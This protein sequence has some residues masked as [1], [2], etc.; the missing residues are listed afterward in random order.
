[1]RSSLAAFRVRVKVRVRF[2]NRVRVSHYP[3]LQPGHSGAD[4]PNLL[5]LGEVVD[6]RDG[7]VGLCEAVA[8]GRSG[9]G[10]LVEHRRD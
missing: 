1:M 8:E 9:G 10:R 7:G 6:G 5:D 4:D 3:R 2:R